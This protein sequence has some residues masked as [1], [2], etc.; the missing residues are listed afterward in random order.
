MNI[1]PIKG[2]KFEDI[3]DAVAAYNPEKKREPKVQP[4]KKPKN[5]KRRGK[6]TWHKQSR[7]YNNS[8]GLSYPFSRQKG[9]G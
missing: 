7:P 4:E 8:C 5:K 1:K 2:K 9:A 3:V 6:K